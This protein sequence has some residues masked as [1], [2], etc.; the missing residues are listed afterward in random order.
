M[1]LPEN[2]NPIPNLGEE[3][4][5]KVFAIPLKDL[6][7]ASRRWVEEGYAIDARVAMFVE[8]IRFA[9]QFTL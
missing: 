2:Q 3:E 7:C 4:F 8:G 6:E 1:S 9:K 5:I